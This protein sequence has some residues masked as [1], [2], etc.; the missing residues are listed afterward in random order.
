MERRY[1]VATLALVATFAIFSREF[2]SGHLANLPCSRAELMADLA[3]AKRYAADRMVARVRPFVHRGVPEEAQMMAELNLPVLAAV[4]EQLAEAQ[5]AVAQKTA[6]KE[7]E[8]A[9]RA[10]VNTERAQA[11][12]E[13]AHEISARAVERAQELSIRANERAAEINARAIERAQRINACAMQRAQR[14]MERSRSRMAQPKVE[15]YPIPINFEVVSPSDFALPMQISLESRLAV[16]SVK[17]QVAAEQFRVETLQR[18]NQ[19]IMNNV[20]VVVTTE[21]V[22]GVDP[23]KQFNGARTLSRQIERAIQHSLQN[24]S[25]AVDRTFARI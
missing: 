12:T 2:R 11:A 3:C 19:K 15:G 22:S 14:A 5:A 9:R 18:A 10:Q 21:D 1:L 17:A 8:A 16:E 13:R 20:Q 6:E 24:I 23:L 4:N 7:C 25:R